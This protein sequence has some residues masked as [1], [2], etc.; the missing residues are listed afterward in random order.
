[1]VKTFKALLYIFFLPALMATKCVRTDGVDENHYSIST[2]DGMKDEI[3]NFTESEKWNFVRDASPLFKCEG[4][5]NFALLEKDKIQP[6]N[7]NVL[8]RVDTKKCELVT[9]WKSHCPL[10]AS[11]EDCNI[12]GGKW[13]LEQDKIIAHHVLKKYNASINEVGS[14]NHIPLKEAAVSCSL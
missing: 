2:C 7:W 4:F 12:A 5:G 8:V 3:I 14:Y 6:Q 11:D 10:G 9:R 1:M 13:Y